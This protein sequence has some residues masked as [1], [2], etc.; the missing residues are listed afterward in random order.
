MDSIDI[1]KIIEQA[2]DEIEHVLNDC[3]YV[4]SSDLGL[5]YRCGKA[6]VGDDCIVVESS[7][8]NTFNYYGGFEYVDKRGVQ[9]LGRYTV[10]Y[11]GWDDRIRQAIDDYNDVY[12]EE[13]VETV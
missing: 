9:E 7:Y 11:A 4:K 10:F 12:D 13:E 8:V 2:E 6:Y 5:D 3:P 1:R